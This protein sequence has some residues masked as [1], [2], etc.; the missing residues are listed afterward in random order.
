[1]NAD[2]STKCAISTISV[3]RFSS[4]GGWLKATSKPRQ[5]ETD[6]TGRCRQVRG[7]AP[8]T[9]EASCK[10]GMGVTSQ[11]ARVGG[12]ISVGG[13]DSDLYAIDK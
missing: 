1:M 4:T 5:N 12:Q 2:T 10:P 3:G 9:E 13:G 6:G 11:D 7:V 8:T